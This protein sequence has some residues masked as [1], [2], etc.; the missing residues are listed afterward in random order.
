MRNPR[1]VVSAAT[2]RPMRLARAEAAIKDKPM[3]EAAFR[4]AARAAAADAAIV[5][6]MQGSA[7]Y[8]RH[9]LEVHLS[10]ALGGLAGSGRGA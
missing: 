9:L 2:E 5:T 1:I 7:A 10:R 3:A 6:D 4:E 8:K